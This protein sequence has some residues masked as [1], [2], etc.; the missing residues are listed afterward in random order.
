MT[1]S[2]VGATGGG[3]RLT[4]RAGGKPAGHWDAA[5]PGPGGVEATI[6][7]LARYLA[8]CLAPPEGPLGTAIRLCQQ[9]RVRIDG[10]PAGGLAWIITGGLLFHD[11]ATGGFSA[12]MAIDQA[13]GHAMAALVNTHGSAAPLLS[14]A[15]KAAVKGSDRRVRPRETGRWRGRNGT[16]EPARWRARCST[17][18][19]PAP[20]RCCIRSSSRR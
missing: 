12:S 10:Q 1:R 17:A 11:G 5:L 9:P 7:D 6:G 14:G 15:V 19:M 3:T 18:T 4:G 8:A 13:A 2:G 16:S 20:A